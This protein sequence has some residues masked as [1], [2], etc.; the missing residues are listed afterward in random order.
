MDIL[1]IAVQRD[2]VRVEEA[3][4]IE[5]YTVLTGLLLSIMSAKEEGNA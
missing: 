4:K 5:E 3:L 2:K 1:W